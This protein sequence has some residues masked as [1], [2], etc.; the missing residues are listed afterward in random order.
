MGVSVYDALAADVAKAGGSIAL[1]SP[2]SLPHFRM[3][4]IMGLSKGRAGGTTSGI[5]LDVNP[6]PDVQPKAVFALK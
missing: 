2:G 4:D 6:R 5:L 3:A 1:A